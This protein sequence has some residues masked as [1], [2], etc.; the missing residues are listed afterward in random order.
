MTSSIDFLWA[1][2]H[3][4]THPRH[5]LLD[6][7]KIFSTPSE[8]VSACLATSSPSPCPLVWPSLCSPC[9]S[10]RKLECPSFSTGHT[11]GQCRECGGHGR[12]HTD[13]SETFAGL[14]IPPLTI[15]RVGEQ[16]PEPPALCHQLQAWAS[17][18]TTSGP[19]I[20]WEDSQNSLEASIRL[21]ML[22]HSEGL[23]VK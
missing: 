19:T 15:F 16:S 13:I 18:K 23:R 4:H 8:H 10:A 7:S 14:Q 6:L 2:L 20:C 1:C 5:R 9:P 17:S 22:Y 11:A 3:A 12:G 21:V